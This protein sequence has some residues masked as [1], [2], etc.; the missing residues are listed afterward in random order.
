MITILTDITEILHNYANIGPILSDI[1]S[2]NQSKLLQ[3]ESSFSLR[4]AHT[5]VTGC[6]PVT[7]C[8][9]LYI[10]SKMITC[11]RRLSFSQLHCPAVNLLFTRNPSN[12][13]SPTLLFP[14]SLSLRSSFFLLPFPISTVH[15]PAFADLCPVCRQTPSRCRYLSSTPLNV[16]PLVLICVK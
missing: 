11:P 12:L 9:S 16:T 2:T 13:L 14:L 15:L 4:R 5:G 3:S 8:F 6:L 7:R 1:P 10:H